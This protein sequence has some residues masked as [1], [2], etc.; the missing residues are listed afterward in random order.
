MDSDI[1]YNM[2]SYIESRIAEESG[3]NRQQQEVQ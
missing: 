2:E 1:D 3:H